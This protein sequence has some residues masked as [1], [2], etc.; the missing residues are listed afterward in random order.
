MEE[1]RDDKD[2]MDLSTK[3]VDSPS[4]PS[5]ASAK[6]PTL[7]SIATSRATA[8]LE[9]VNFP[10][11]TCGEMFPSRA[12][13]EQHITDRHSTYV[14]VPPSTHSSS[15]INC[16]CLFIFST[17]FYCH[18]KPHSCNNSTN[19]FIS[20]PAPFFSL[21]Q[22]VRRLQSLS[23]LTDFDVFLTSSYFT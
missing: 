6:S 3:A 21:F 5:L 22:L 17:S 12:Q 14:C 7:N 13:Q 16:S 9:M 19:I 2:P 18:C 8:E 4:V 10:C 20:L 1:E 15:V 11:H 23:H